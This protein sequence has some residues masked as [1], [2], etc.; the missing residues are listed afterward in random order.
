MDVRIKFRIFLLFFGISTV[1]V[2]QPDHKEYHN[3]FGGAA[4]AVFNQEEA[5][6]A[7][8]LYL[9]YTY[10]FSGTLEKFGIGPG[11][12]AI[13]DEHMHYDASFNVT[14]RPVH[15]LWISAGPGITFI[16]EN[17]V[18]LMS[19]HLESGY[20]F[21]AGRMHLGPIIEYSRAGG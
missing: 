21:E 1:L 12:E 6:V 17:N 9:H 15:Q 18:Y 5:N 10:M 11:L 3:E 2:G 14:W 7:L 13:I 16:Q 8:G 19:Y 4:G 20:E